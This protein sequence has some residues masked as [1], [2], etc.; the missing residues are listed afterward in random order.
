[1]ARQCTQAIEHGL[2]APL[3]DELRPHEPHVHE[4]R[5]GRHAARLSLRDV[6]SLDELT[7]SLGV[8]RT[9]N[10][11]GAR[12]EVWLFLNA[13]TSETGIR[14]WA[15]AYELFSITLVVILVISDIV[16]SV[17]EIAYTKAESNMYGVFIKTACAIFTAEYVLRVWSCLDSETFAQS[18]PVF[19]RMRYCLSLLPLIDSIV[20]VAFF[21]DIFEASHSEFVSVLRMV[22]LLRILALL[23]LERSTNSF[24]TIY[25]V[26]ILKKPELIAT[27][28][29]ACVLMVVSATLMYYLENSAQPDKF[30]NILVAMWWGVTALTTVGYGDIFP[31]T[32]LGKFTASV[33]AFFGVGLFA[34][35]AGI[36]GSGFVEILGERPGELDEGEE[37][38]SCTPAGAIRSSPSEEVRKLQGDIA[39]V[40][41]DMMSFQQQMLEATQAMSSKMETLLKNQALLAEFVRAQ[42]QNV[43]ARVAIPGQAVNRQTSGSCADGGG[44]IQSMPG[45]FA[46]TPVMPKSPTT[47]PY[48]G[49]QRGQHAALSPRLQHQSA[50]KGPFT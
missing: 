38:L 18:G 35:P 23:K 25:K 27:L 37:S 46:P 14:K 40:K 6:H 15:G 7:A 5:H 50:L 48:A 4:G 29:T 44:S 24:R 2:A 20:L 11:S 19:G 9:L 49:W 3:L 30:P 32:P 47:S 28:F 43:V 26:F 17:D 8:G 39:E 41:S 34:L 31:I 1:M 22:R 21:F 42:Q 13:E 45:Q 12:H 36:L 16:D 33:V 10:T